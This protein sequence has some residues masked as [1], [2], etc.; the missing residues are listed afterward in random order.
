MLQNTVLRPRK[1]LLEFENKVQEQESTT[2]L[3]A[4][5][6]LKRDRVQFFHAE[7]STPCEQTNL[8]PK[9]RLFPGR[10]KGQR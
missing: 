3:H 5:D 2:T 4:Q 1:L 6:A 9:F 10:N 7:Q 8:S